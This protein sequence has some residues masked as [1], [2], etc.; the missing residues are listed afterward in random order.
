M[1]KYSVVITAGDKE[2]YTVLELD[3]RGIDKDPVKGACFQVKSLINCDDVLYSA[4][5]Q[6]ALYI[7]PDKLTGVEVAE[8]P[9]PEVMNQEPVSPITPGDYRMYNFVTT[10]LGQQMAVSLLV[11]NQDNATIVMPTVINGQD[12]FNFM[13]RENVQYLAATLARD[14]LMLH[15]GDYTVLLY[16]GPVLD[17]TDA[18]DYIRD[19]L[20]D[21]KKRAATEDKNAK[22]YLNWKGDK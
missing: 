20:K 16:P 14:S 4:D 10:F 12:A 2:F 9:E 22:A 15:P 19:W 1:K 13:G 11:Y 5:T 21:N 17:M 6:K 18:V 7:N 3:T 8:I